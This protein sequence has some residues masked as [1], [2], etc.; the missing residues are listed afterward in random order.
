MR[1]GGLQ[2]CEEL[3]WWGVVG[4]GWIYVCWYYLGLYMFVSIWYRFQASTG[5]GQLILMLTADEVVLV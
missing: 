1:S 5:F 3:G 4:G 2:S